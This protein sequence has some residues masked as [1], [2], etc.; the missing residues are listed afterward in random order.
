M[1]IQ[2]KLLQVEFASS[3]NNIICTVKLGRGTQDTLQRS[4]FAEWTE[5][6]YRL[7]PT[8]S[9][10]SLLFRARTNNMSGNIK[11]L[12]WPPNGSFINNSSPGVDISL[13]TSEI[14]VR[15][16]ILIPC[17][18]VWEW[19]TKSSVVINLSGL[20]EEIKINLFCYV[21]L[22][23]FKYDFECLCYSSCY[24]YKIKF[25][26]VPKQMRKSR[27]GLTANSRSEDSWRIR[28]SVHTSA[29]KTA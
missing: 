29:D 22:R 16:W 10:I 6:D 9:F 5:L 17:R 4:T 28:S 13:E 15:N 27:I 25:E 3:W 24:V 7:L 18:S 11:T 12:H 20:V 21:F 14:C 19:I 23:R 2:E 8:S 26:G 1:K